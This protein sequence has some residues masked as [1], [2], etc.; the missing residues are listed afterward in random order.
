MKRVRE[1]M[2]DPRVQTPAKLMQVFWSTQRAMVLNPDK[3]QRKYVKRIMQILE[4]V[5]LQQE[6]MDE[7]GIQPSSILEL[8]DYLKSPYFREAL[9][10]A[11]QGHGYRDLRRFLQEKTKEKENNALIEANH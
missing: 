8:A 3:R 1:L 9:E 6:V 11:R 2:F 10:F 5:D 7:D 4:S